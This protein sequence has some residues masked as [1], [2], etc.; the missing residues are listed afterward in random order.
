MAIG[1]LKM[2]AN[3]HFCSLQACLMRRERNKG[4]NRPMKALK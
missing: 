2:A 1:R 4:M 3:G